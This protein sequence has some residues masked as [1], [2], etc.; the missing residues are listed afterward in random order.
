MLLASIPPKPLT[1]TVPKCKK[2]GEGGES[3]ALRF[4]SNPSPSFGGLRRQEAAQGRPSLGSA[5]K[6]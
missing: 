1:R 3:L 4:L 2:Q 5:M 6:Q